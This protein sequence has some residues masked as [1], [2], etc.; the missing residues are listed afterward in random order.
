MVVVAVTAS[1]GRG[2][3]WG[4][5]LGDPHRGGHFAGGHLRAALQ[6]TDNTKGSTPMQ[7][8]IHTSFP[9]SFLTYAKI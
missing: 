6:H 5:I 8:A 4:D 1:G 9:M 2:L 7:G 3:A